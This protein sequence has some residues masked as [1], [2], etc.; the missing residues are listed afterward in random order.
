MCVGVNVCEIECVLV[1]VLD[2]E[3]ERKGEC[4]TMS[5]SVCVRDKTERK[6][7]WETH[8]WTQKETET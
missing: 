7:E 6:G 8:R 5:V 3:T 4:V 1:C 2:S